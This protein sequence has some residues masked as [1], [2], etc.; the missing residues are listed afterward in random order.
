MFGLTK[1]QEE[2]LNKLETEVQQLKTELSSL[3]ESLN[4]RLATGKK[5]S[6][7][8]FAVELLSKWSTNMDMTITS[9]RK[10]VE[11][12]SPDECKKIDLIESFKVSN[13]HEKLLKISLGKNNINSNDSGLIHLDE[14]LVAILRWNVTKYLNLLESIMI[15]WQRGLVEP[16]I[17]EDEFKFLLSASGKRFTLSTYRDE[18]LN[19]YGIEPYPAIRVFENN[20]I[21]SSE[22]Y[23]NYKNNY[24]KKINDNILELKKQQASDI[25]TIKRI[26]EQELNNYRD[27][28]IDERFNMIRFLLSESAKASFPILAQKVFDILI[29]LIGK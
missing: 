14:G 7:E 15:A 25:E 2:K 6:R 23:A 29:S 8:K 19:I 12:L 27:S 10:V 1:N 24:L 4:I 17:I 16:E 18:I 26:V 22:K 20:L 21:L 11:R 28:N 5:T 3:N 13:N 9:T